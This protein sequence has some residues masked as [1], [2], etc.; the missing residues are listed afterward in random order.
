MLYFYIYWLGVQL[1]ISIWIEGPF[2]AMGSSQGKKMRVFPRFVFM[3]SCRGVLFQ[4][5]RTPSFL[6]LFLG[7]CSWNRGILVKAVVWCVGKRGIFCRYS[8]W[9]PWWMRS[10]LIRG[11]CWRIM[12]LGGMLLV[13]G[14]MIIKCWSSSLDKYLCVRVLVFYFHVLYL[15]ALFGIFLEARSELFGNNWEE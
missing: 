3:V 5:L 10:G 1:L 2:S 6:L 15:W 9:W 11:F 8:L 7:F 13:W 12:P 4:V 14:E